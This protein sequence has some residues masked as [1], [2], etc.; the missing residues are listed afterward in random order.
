MAPLPGPIGSPTSQT[1][2][3][4]HL[5]LPVGDGMEEGDVGT[6]P[7]SWPQFPASFTLTGHTGARF[8]GGNYITN[9]SA[10][11][12]LAS[13][14][15]NPQIITGGTINALVWLLMAINCLSGSLLSKCH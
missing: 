3:A 13:L 10:P 8:H 7:L 11:M 12:L 9:V 6:R 1:R 5:L 2:R 4:S 15:Q 14:S